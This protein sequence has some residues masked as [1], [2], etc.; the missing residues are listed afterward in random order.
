MWKS[1]WS[2]QVVY[3]HI[4]PCK[5]IAWSMR[6]RLLPWRQAKHYFLHE[7]YAQTNSEMLLLQCVQGQIYKIVVL[8]QHRK[9]SHK[10][11]CKSLPLKDER[12]QLRLGRD[13]TGSTRPEQQ[14][15]L[16]RR[17]VVQGNSQ[18]AKCK[19]ETVVAE[20]HPFWKAIRHGMVRSL[21]L[22]ISKLFRGTV[23]AF[24]VLYH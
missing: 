11:L 23:A 5:I 8:Q 6:S 16:S 13:G 20:R 22:C 10:H 7:G 9:S 1:D 12:I 15:G 3:S 24:R 19:L 17:R 2:K 21:L 14:A 4:P 18:E